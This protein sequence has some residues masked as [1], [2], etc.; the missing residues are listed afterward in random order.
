MDGAASPA[1]RCLDELQ[2]I[3]L[4]TV[5]GNWRHEQQ[6]CRRPTIS[7]IQIE[8][9]LLEMAFSG[10]VGFQSNAPDCTLLSVAINENA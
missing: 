10:F 5:P 9:S 6:W 1:R 7:F 4:V 8:G 3:G 2:A